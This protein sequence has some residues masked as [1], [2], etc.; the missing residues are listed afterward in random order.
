MELCSQS[1]F[2]FSLKLFQQLQITLPELTV[3]REEGGLEGETNIF[4]PL[5]NLFQKPPVRFLM[6]HW[7]ELSYSLPKPATV[8]SLELRLYLLEQGQGCLIFP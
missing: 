4:S 8:I 6:F 2:P 3:A 7:E 1:D 5:G